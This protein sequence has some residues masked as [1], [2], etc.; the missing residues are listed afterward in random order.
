M[1]N[2]E[3]VGVDTGEQKEV[4]VTLI[5]AAMP[6]RWNE[7]LSVREKAWRKCCFKYDV[8]NHKKSQNYAKSEF[9]VILNRLYVY[10]I[11]EL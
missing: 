6:H 1:L 8:R 11:E 4:R 7:S 9:M 5:C 10:G 2:T 3:H